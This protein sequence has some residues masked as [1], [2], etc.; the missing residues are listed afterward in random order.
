M[1]WSGGEASDGNEHFD[2]EEERGAKR[3]K[4]MSVH[5]CKVFRHSQSAWH[6]WSPK[7]WVLYL[8][9]PIVFSQ[10]LPCTLAFARDL[11]EDFPLLHA[12]IAWRLPPR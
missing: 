11:S 8:V 4:T 10:V 2:I 12:R 1:E 3:V 6:P 9:D 5:G 7:Y